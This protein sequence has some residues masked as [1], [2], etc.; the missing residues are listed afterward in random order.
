MVVEG[1]KGVLELLKSS[2][3]TERI[4]VTSASDFEEIKMLAKEKDVEVC[5]VSTNDMEIMSS[6]KKPPGVLAVGEIS[7][8]SID[9]LIQNI[10]SSD[11]KNVPTL[12]LLD[13]L[14]DPGNVGTLIRTAHWFG[15]VGVICSPKTVDVW[16]AKAIQSSMGSVFNIPIVVDDLA[17]TI[18]THNLN[19]AALDAGGT[20]IHEGNSI[21]NAII[22]GSESHGLSENIKQICQEIW[23]IPGSGQAESLNASIAGAIVCSEVSRRWN[24]LKS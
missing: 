14:N 4:Y 15:F 24:S 8:S 12:L 10:N 13:D 2:L 22:V 7:Y 6:M 18:S 23:A 17:Q 1:S 19:C 9:Q 21:P 3:I 20:S 16:N 11:H 5:D